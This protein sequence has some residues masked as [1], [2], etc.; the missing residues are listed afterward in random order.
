MGQCAAQT[1]SN[2]TPHKWLAVQKK[3]AANQV[4]LN[5][6][7]GETAQQGFTFSWHYD[8]LSPILTIPCLNRPLWAPHAAP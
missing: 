8:A 4:I 5:G 7:S 3:A 6:D 2:I 1:F